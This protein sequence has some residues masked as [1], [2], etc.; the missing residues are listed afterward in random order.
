MELPFTV[1]QFFQVFEDHNLTTWPAPVVAYVF[2]IAGV[3]Y[4]IKRTPASSSIV[5]SILALLWIWM[6]AVYHI[7]FFA[8]INRTAYVFG[9]LFLLQGA[10]FLVVG[11]FRGRISF[12]SQWSAYGITGLLFV[13]YAIVLYPLLGMQFGH[14]YPRAPAFGVAPCPTTIFTLGLLLWTNRGLPRY[15]LIIPALWSLIGF[16]AAAHLGVYEDYGLVAAGVVGAA[17]VLY[18]ERKGKRPQPVHDVYDV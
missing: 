10:L 2:G 18:R 4:A 12:G 5:C 16:S 8:A 6:G 7:A 3:L 11:A 1:E 17:M 13:V 15:I 14:G 9:A